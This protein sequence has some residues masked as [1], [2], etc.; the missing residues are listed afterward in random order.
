MD[1]LV[2]AEACIE[3]ALALRPSHAQVKELHEKVNKRR[4]YVEG[5]EKARQERERRQKSEKLNLEI[6]L[7]V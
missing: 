2:E 3:N 7:K 4:A 5:L 1:R 6:A